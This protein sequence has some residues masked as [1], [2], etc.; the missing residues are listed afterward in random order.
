MS[1]YAQDDTVSAGP[2]AEPAARPAWRRSP[3]VRLV[4]FATGTALVLAGFA[5]G[6]IPFLPG[7]PLGIAG[8]FLLSLSSR[9][10]RGALRRLTGRLP[11]RWRDRF[12]FLHREP[13]RR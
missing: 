6:F 9:R 5:L 2:P 4:L 11:A 7:F 13:R 8:I 10:M 1:N 3:A 12:H